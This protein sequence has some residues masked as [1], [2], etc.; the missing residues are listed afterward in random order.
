MNKLQISINAL[1]FT[2]SCIALYLAIGAVGK[3]K[4]APVEIAPTGWQ[5]ADLIRD[6]KHPENKGTI[7]TS[8]GRINL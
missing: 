8:G 7:C 2:I 4:E 3:I 1:S 5:C 6:R